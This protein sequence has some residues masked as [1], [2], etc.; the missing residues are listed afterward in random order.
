MN[1]GQKGSGERDG[2]SLWGHSENSL[3]RTV[4]SLS[5]FLFLSL[6]LRVCRSPSLVLSVI[7]TPFQDPPGPAVFAG[8]FTEGFPKRASQGFE[9]RWDCEE[10]PVLPF[11]RREHSFASLFI[12][13]LFSS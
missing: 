11:P 12:I 3:E 2:L 7:Y 13:L 10:G 5:F 1:G 8:G 9:R 6:L 4:A